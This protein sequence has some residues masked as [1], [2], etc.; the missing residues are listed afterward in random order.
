M[1]AGVS[2][3]AGLP[4]STLSQ[5]LN[6]ELAPRYRLVILGDGLVPAKINNRGVVVGTDLNTNHPFVYRHGR[7]TELPL[8]RGDT[9]G[10]ASDVNNREQIV[11]FSLNPDVYVPN[12]HNCPPVCL[13]THALLYEHRHV[14]NLGQIPGAINWDNSADLINDSGEIVGESGTPNE[15]GGSRQIT[16]FV[17]GP[18]RAVPDAY[19]GLSSRGFPTGLN[20]AG[21]I[22]G[23]HYDI[24]GSLF[25]YPNT[26]TCSP[27]LVFLYNGFTGI[28]NAG[29]TISAPSGG[30]EGVTPAPPVY[31]ERGV[32]HQ[33]Q[34]SPLAINDR[35]DIVGTATAPQGE[36]YSQGTFHEIAAMTTGHRDASSSST[37]TGT[38]PGNYFISSDGTLQGYVMSF[39]PGDALLYSKGRYYDLNDLVPNHRGIVLSN[40]VSINIRREIVG[41]Y[42]TASSEAGYLLVPDRDND[43][44]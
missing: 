16:I 13:Q 31:C 36:L 39:S 26:I 21:E 14:I 7:V 1:P 24:L 41:S 12:L 43:D 2:H 33:L 30:A 15:E 3:G 17:P 42:R 20:N 35:G 10:G 18:V 8:W 23:L 38:R 29:N 34:L 27:P 9:L 40:P 4:E 6:A 19:D 44:R 5:T 32:G 28:N 11:G 37:I 25:A 22:V